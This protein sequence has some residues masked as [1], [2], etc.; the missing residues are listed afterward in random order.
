[1][2]D[3]GNGGQANEDTLERA[4]G[5]AWTDDRAWN[6]LTNLTELPHRMGGSAGERRALN[7]SGQPRGRRTR[8]RAG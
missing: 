6:L 3:H 8:G 7:P 4:L 1:M 2:A 5:R